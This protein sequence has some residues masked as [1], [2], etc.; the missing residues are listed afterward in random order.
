MEP[1]QDI[2]SHLD[3][4]PPDPILGMALAYKADP[5]P[6]KVNLSIGAYR[7]DEGVPYVFQSI[8]EAEAEI[9][10]DKTLDKVKLFF[11]KFLKRL[12][13]L[14]SRNT[15]QSMDFKSLTMKPRNYSSDQKTH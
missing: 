3:L 13:P 14:Y 15:F 7:T 5:S 9:L 4:A 11:R 10:Q 1:Q 8:R 2:F 6:N 12:P